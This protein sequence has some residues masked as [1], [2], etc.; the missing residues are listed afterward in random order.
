MSITVWNPFSEMEAFLDRFNNSVRKNNKGENQMFEVGD[1]MPA[2][3]INETSDSFIVKTELPG[4]EKEDVNVNLENNVLT[5][6]GE[7]KT[8]I[9]DSK[10]HR[11]ECSYGSF[12][13]SFTLPQTVDV[14]KIE[15]E[16]K[17]GILTLTVPKL[18][19]EKPKQIE[20]KIK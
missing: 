9:K 11:T 8:E 1:W 7:K 3:D 16:Y 2:V 13:R 4:V 20:V 15:A 5:I 10:Q 17:D 19:E 18:T 12:T 14:E 6:K